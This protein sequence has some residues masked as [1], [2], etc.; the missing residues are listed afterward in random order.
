MPIGKVLALCL[1]AVLIASP[2][3]G[4]A[5]A[6]NE[7]TFEVDPATP[8]I[9]YARGP[10]TAD[11][12][13]A[14][15]LFANTHAIQPG[16]VLVLDS[17][18]GNLDSGLKLG[19]IVRDHLLQTRVGRSG[20]I[21]DGN[22]DNAPRCASA[23]NFV[24]MG[25]VRRTVPEGTYF[26]VH[27]FVPAD[28]DPVVAAGAWSVPASPATP[29]E[30]PKEAEEGAQE[31][32]GILLRFVAQ[33]GIS[34]EYMILMSQTPNARPT[35]VGPNDLLALRIVTPDIPTEWSL[36]GEQGFLELRGSTIGPTGQKDVLTF[37]CDGGT[38]IAAIAYKP[39]APETA[40]GL[41]SRAQAIRFIGLPPAKRAMFE[42]VPLRPPVVF[43]TQQDGLVRTLRVDED[44]D[45]D[46]AAVR[47]TPSLLDLLDTQH[48]IK[49]E[50]GAFSPAST[51][52]LPQPNQYPPL[53][54][55]NEYPPLIGQTIM[56]RTG[57]TGDTAPRHEMP[58]AKEWRSAWNPQS[59]QYGWGFETDMS[60]ARSEL[61]TFLS[62]CHQ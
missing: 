14:F 35:A 13:A 16:S 48:I 55:Q 3:K 54:G 5:A 8:S 45:I 42:I 40:K 52:G 21:D 9:V 7:M 60:A 15:V 36:H 51:A 33:M 37:V 11:T 38:P 44:A 27:R 6:S 25:G 10:I 34:P 29:R 28:P 39:D 18:G 56:G 30:T 49:V 41:A 19:R 20:W 23:C 50:I 57:N 62:T 17:G 4:C 47:L 46:V 26:V 32:S 24:F 59:I 58:W 31:E 43:A 12:P 61:K 22:I 2:K 53:I 1:I